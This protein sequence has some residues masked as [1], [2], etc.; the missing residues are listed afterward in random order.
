MLKAT[1][2]DYEVAERSRGVA[3][4]GIGVIHKMVTRIGLPKAIDRRLLLLKKHL[5]YWESD[6]VLNIAYN[7]V[8]GG[9][10]LE[11]LELLRNN[12]A[13]LDALGAQRI[14]DPTTAGDY[15]RRFTES[16]V[17]QLMESYNEVRVRVWKQ[18]DRRFF[19]QAVID[20]D[21]TLAPTTG[22][23]KEGMDISY[24]GD[25]GYHPLLVSLANT[26]EPL[27]LVNRRGNRPSHEGAAERLDQSIA[28]PFSA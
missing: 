18:Q 13:Y 14:P 15:C 20:V 2:I 3:T 24:K 9:R 27:F 28:L 10:C 16:N 26:G 25:W 7:V 11:D 6:H 1:G 19:D 12:E 4:G 5:P 8:C 17:E 21:G 22:E 23:K